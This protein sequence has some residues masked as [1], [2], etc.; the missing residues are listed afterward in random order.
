M[1]R[2]PYVLMM[3]DRRD[4]ATMFA[5]PHSGRDYPW[6]FIRNSQLD[7]QT[8][9][10]SEDAFVDLLFE[11]APDF[12][13]PLLTTVIPRAYVDLN[14]HADELD[15]ALIVGSK[16]GLNNPRVM[17][18]LGVIPRVVANGKAIRR[19]KI[20]MSEARRRLD[21]FYHP[22]HRVLGRLMDES[23]AEFGFALLFDCH[24]MPHDALASTSFA[25]DKKPEIVLGDRFGAACVSDIVDA[26]EAEFTAAGLRV[27]RNL[28]FA[29]AHVAQRYGRPAD[30]HHAIQIEIDRSVYMDE[31]ALEPNA[32]F[33]P[34]RR[35][36]RSIVGKLAELGR[37]EVRLAAE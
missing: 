33:E 10:S 15:P 12:G 28:P 16:T 30:G 18:G 36:M 32:N 29:G 26:A 25:H 11:S 5:S 21:G 19:G 35:K 9:R 8:I 24:S 4:T 22:Y 1:S 14:R 34:F 3:P 13:S 7:E 6:G 17:A 31:A 27:A 23:R 2:P 20:D 37:G